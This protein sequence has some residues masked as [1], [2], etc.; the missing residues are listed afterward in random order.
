MN[1]KLVLD[2]ADTMNAL[3]AIPNLISLLLLNNVIIKDTYKYLWLDN[4]D[5]NDGVDIPKI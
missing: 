2:I 1:L 4:L 5:R 3:M